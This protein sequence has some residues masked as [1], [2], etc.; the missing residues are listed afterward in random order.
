MSNTFKEVHE[1]LKE[2]YHKLLDNGLKECV[3]SANKSEKEHIQKLVKLCKDAVVD[4]EP[5]IDY[6]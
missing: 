1:D 2:C 6:C 3:D 4:F 5:I